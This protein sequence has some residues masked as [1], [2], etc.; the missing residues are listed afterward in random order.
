[1]TSLVA[2]RCS[3]G[4]VIGADS[5]AT[6][7]DGKHISTIEQPT[8]RKIEIIGEQFIVAGT[9]YVG[10]GQRFCAV[11]N[12]LFT[13]K[14][15]KDKNDKEVGKILSQY[16]IAD[17]KETHLQRFEYSAFV[18]Y[19]ALDKPCLCELPGGMDFQPEIKEPTDNLWFASAGSGQ[20]ITDPFL[21]H[22]RQVFWHDGP[23]KLHGG[24]FMALWALRHACELNPGGI[25]EPIHMAVLGREKGKLR[26]RKLGE[27][28]LMEHANM[29][30]DATRH[31]AS[32]R[33]VLEGRTPTPPLP[34][35]PIT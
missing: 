11:V 25:K 7:G 26:A 35:K 3:D 30:Q 34:V 8:N 33:E 10:H 13:E 4:V 9:G 18:A 14:G 23:P 32:F 21:A 17:F 1:M 29:V 12:R 27:D 19:P 24:I 20:Q 22:L 28:E 15:F 31:L 6:F 16:G 2:I 5:S